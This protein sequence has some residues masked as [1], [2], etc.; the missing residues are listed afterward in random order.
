MYVQ[1]EVDQFRWYFLFS[2]LRILIRSRPFF[3]EKT[4]HFYEINKFVNAIYWFYS[5]KICSDASWTICCNE[6]F[7]QLRIRIRPLQFHLPFQ[8]KPLYT[9][10]CWFKMQNIFRR[11]LNKFAGIFLL[12]VPDFRSVTAHLER[13]PDPGFGPNRPEAAR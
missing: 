9:I 12:S 3:R 11:Y 2:Q 8:I 10:I 13:D 5:K 1:T 7:T 6:L 4:F